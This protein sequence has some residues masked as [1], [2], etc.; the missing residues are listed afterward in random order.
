MRN[1]ESYKKYEKYENDPKAALQEVKEVVSKLTRNEDSDAASDLSPKDETFIL[2]NSSIP[3]NVCSVLMKYHLETITEDEQ[4]YCKDIVIHTASTS[5]R[6]GYRYQIGDGSQSAISVLPIL[7]DH[8]PEDRDIIKSILLLT[9]FDEYP[10]DMG[11]TVFNAFAIGAVHEL[12]ENNFE[13]A[14]S[15]LLGYLKLKPK[16][17]E[18]HERLR[19]ENINKGVY[20]RSENKEIDKF[21]AENEKA[22]YDI[23][24]NNV[25]L[26][27]IGDIKKLDLRVLKTAFLMIPLKTN[28]IEHMKIVKDIVPSF[29]EILLS[30]DKDD[31]IDY[32]VEHDFLEKLAYFVLS[33]LE[34]EVEEY[35]KPFLDGFNSSEGIADLFVEFISAEDHLDTYDKF[36]QVWGLFKDKVIKICEKGDRVWYVDKIL[37]SYLFAEIHWKAT[38]TEWHTLKD[39]DKSFLKEM[40]QKTS[41]CPSTLYAISRLLNDIGS[42]YLND[43]ISWIS[44]MLNNNPGLMEAELVTNTIYYIENIARKYIYNNR[45]KIR[46]SSRSKKEVLVIL[47]YL[48]EKGSVVG[49]M[50]R[51]NIL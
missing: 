37:R 5:L 7:L 2:M 24:E 38:A 4:V 14:Q 3:G 13:T 6:P 25:S 28:N 27:E 18:L 8:F 30:R 48:I 32:K 36:W 46:R 33:S 10:I 1:D 43:G 40:S 11:G 26:E 34:E 42:S 21:L 23:S 49:Y 50:L 12:W 17:E 15:L 9:L 19:E 45:E 41:H 39:S 16:Y 22:V 29:T 47:D 20:G 31:R 51:E 35:L 44:Y